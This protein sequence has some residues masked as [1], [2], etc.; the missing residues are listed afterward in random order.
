ML[1][2]R[3]LKILLPDWQA[4]A[5]AAD[6]SCNRLARLPAGLSSLGS[7]GHLRASRNELGGCRDTWQAIS[8][9]TTLTNLALDHNR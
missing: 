7:L 8:S 3:M 6:L 1:L 9:L 5:Q 2:A 4:P